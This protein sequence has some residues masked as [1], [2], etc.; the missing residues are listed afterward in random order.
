MTTYHVSRSAHLP[1]PPDRVHALLNDLREWRRWSPWEELDPEMSR[2]YSGSDAGPGARYSWSGKK[3]AGT[4]SME[5]TSSTPERIEVALGFTKPFKST[6]TVTFELEPADEGTQ[7]VW[8]NAGAQGG[9]S[10]LLLKVFP[11][12]KVL[13]PDME[14]GLANLESVLAADE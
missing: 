12:E 1:G 10:G 2:T 13:A 6:S 9:L 7:L 11:M 3:R 14:K 8:S 4:G 5:I